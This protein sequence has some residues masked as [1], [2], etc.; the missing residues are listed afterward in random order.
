MKIKTREI[1]ITS[2][3]KE[4]RLSLLEK[5]Y[6]LKNQ[7]A[8]RIGKPTIEFEKY[9]RTKAFK[10]ELRN[11]SVAQTQIRIELLEELLANPL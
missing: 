9:A 3:E 1:R 8:L 5:L 10:Q 2:Q 4:E 7:H 6:Q 11:W